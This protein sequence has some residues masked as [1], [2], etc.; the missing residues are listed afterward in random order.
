MEGTLFM[1]F[2]FKLKYGCQSEFISKRYSYIYKQ[3]KNAIC[4][5]ALSERYHKK[6]DADCIFYWELFGNCY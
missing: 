2:D 3:E 1:K 5:L 4:W 6:S